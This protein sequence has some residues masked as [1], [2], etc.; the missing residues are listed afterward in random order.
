MD[1]EPSKEVD[2]YAFGTVVYEVITGAHPYGE[3]KL[4]EIPVLTV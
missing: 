2:M 3:R 4:V 1:A